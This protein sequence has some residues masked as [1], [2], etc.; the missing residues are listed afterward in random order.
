VQQLKVKSVK[1]SNKNL[2]LSPNNN[3]KRNMS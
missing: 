1:M 2:K 3:V